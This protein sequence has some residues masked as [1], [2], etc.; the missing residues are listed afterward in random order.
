MTL[1]P[2]KLVACPKCQGLATYQTLE[3]GNTFGARCWSDGKQ[4]AP[5]LPRPPAFVKCRHCPECY[6]LS[7]AKEVGELPLAVRIDQVDP[8][9]LAAEDVEEPTEEQYYAAIA[10]TSWT[11]R[12]QE[13]TLRILAWHR[14]ND[15]FREQSDAEP[16]IQRT[17]TGALRNNLELLAE[18]LDEADENDLILH[19]EILRQLGKFQAATEILNRIDSPEY[20][21][22]VRQ[23]RALCDRQDACLS[24]LRFDD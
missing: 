2:T 11:S 6:W 20:S 8:A 1:G 4:I 12:E 18:L 14:A 7:D 3:S 10:A 23:L 13:N 22:V 15:P 9:W 17:L 21:Q 19:A 5:M 24:E 16:R